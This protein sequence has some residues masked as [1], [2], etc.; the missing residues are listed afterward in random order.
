[1]R[2]LLSRGALRGT[3]NGG[4]LQK[5]GQ[6]GAS[7]SRAASGGIARRPA[8]AVAVSSA[9]VLAAIAALTAVP[10]GASTRARAA[11]ANC[12]TLHGFYGPARIRVVDGQVSCQT[13]REVFRD[14]FAGRG[15][16][17]NSSEGHAYSYTTVDG[18]ACGTATGT[19]A[20]SAGVPAGQCGC[21]SPHGRFIQLNLAF[22]GSISCISG[23]V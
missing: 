19:S 20:C 2:T 5:E 9:A 7:T 12:G 22:K 23:H 16:K 18:W 15:R 4:V 14:Y 1:M 21:A 13:A 6:V 3:G 10:A 8:R 17:H 11:T